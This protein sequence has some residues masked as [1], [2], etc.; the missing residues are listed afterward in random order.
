VC[1]KRTKW[2]LRIRSAESAAA[3]SE[4][5][6]P[7]VRRERFEAQAALMAAGDGE[8]MPLDEDLL[9]ATEYGMPPSGDM[10]MGSTRCS[11]RSRAQVSARPSAF[12][13]VR[14]Q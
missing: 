3:Y 10:G 5:L 6:A 12:P 2:D 8:A 14:P 4:L 7:V 1:A 9:T 11:W 13:L